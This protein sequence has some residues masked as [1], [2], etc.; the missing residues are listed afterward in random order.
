MAHSDDLTGFYMF[1]GRA[2]PLHTDH[3]GPRAV[4]TLQSRRVTA[5]LRLRL[6]T[7]DGLPDRADLLMTCAADCE[8]IQKTSTMDMI[9]P[10]AEPISHLSALIP[11]LPCDVIFT[12]TPSGIGYGMKP[13]RNYATP[14]SLTPVTNNPSTPKRTFP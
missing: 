10:V 9:F 12:G 1:A 4:P 14:S 8:Q 13:P 7:P 5:Q 11:L 2:G 3:P 6:V